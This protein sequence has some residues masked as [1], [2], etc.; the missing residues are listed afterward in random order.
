MMSRLDL[1]S[2]LRAA[3][4]HSLGSIAIALLALAL[5]F[6]VWYP[7][8][9]ARIA[10]GIDLFRV[11]VAVDVALGP[12]A[13]FAVFDR[14]K[15]W[16]VLRKDLAV[17]LL[18]QTGALLYGLHVLFEARPVALALEHN[19]FRVVSASEVV[20]GEL[21][22]AP[23]ELRT[24]P[25]HGPRLL[26]TEVPSDEAERM[27]TLTAALAGTDLAQRPRYWRSWDET[28]RAQL[29]TEARPLDAL[30]RS[31]PDAATVLDAAVAGTGLPRD[32]LRYLPLIARRAEWV[33]LVDM[34]TGDPAGFAALVGD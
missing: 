18:L 12:L 34:E 15:G 1:G 26:R 17:I 6:F 13:T 2:R 32:R 4:V 21:P 27:G 30:L 28:A 8:P 29:R 3:T 20:R 11:L 5:V 23:E 7:H 9:Y 24:L 33:V 10:G 16:P 19:R 31:A 25:L 14:S 22:A